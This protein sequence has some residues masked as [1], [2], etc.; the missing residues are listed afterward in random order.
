MPGGL[1]LQVLQYA[2]EALPIICKF[3]G[4]FFA[5][6]ASPRIRGQT[7]RGTP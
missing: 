5:P 2:I 3:A 1:S 7:K 4:F 6:L